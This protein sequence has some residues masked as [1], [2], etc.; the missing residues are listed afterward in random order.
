MDVH[1]LRERTD[2][3]NTSDYSREKL[4]I[5]GLEI[6]GHLGAPAVGGAPRKL[7]GPPNGSS[8]DGRNAS[9][10]CLR[11]AIFASS[12]SYSWNP[13]RLPGLGR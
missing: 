5:S 10:F 6:A 13:I 1:Y 4:K 9:I 2:P 12:G 3:A 7:R 11:E 8:P